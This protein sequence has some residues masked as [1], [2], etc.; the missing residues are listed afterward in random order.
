MAITRFLWLSGFVTVF[1]ATG[2]VEVLAQEQPSGALTLESL[3]S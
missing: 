1:S 2:S 3:P